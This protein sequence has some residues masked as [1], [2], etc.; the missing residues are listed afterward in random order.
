MV[1]VAGWT[2]ELQPAL[3]LFGPRFA[4]ASHRQAG[5][6]GAPTFTRRTTE[7]LSIDCCARPRI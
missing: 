2:K 5:A 7:T 3:S 6:A 1:W 4:D